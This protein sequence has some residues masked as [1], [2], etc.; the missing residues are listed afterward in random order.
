MH[1]LL[2]S[3]FVST[4]S[5]CFRGPGVKIQYIAR[6]LSP[7]KPGALKTHAN[8]ET[9]FTLKEALED[10]PTTLQRAGTTVQAVLSNQIFTMGP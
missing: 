6:F 1:V 2:L 4:A 7:K 8:E 9:P 5:L 3:S 10:L